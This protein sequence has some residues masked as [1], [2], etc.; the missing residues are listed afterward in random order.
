MFQYWNIG[1]FDDKKC[2]DFCNMWNKRISTLY[3]LT[4]AA[5]IA[6]IILNSEND[7]Q[8]TSISDLGIPKM[9]SMFQYW[10]IGNSATKKYN[11][12]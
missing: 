7:N 9:A 3:K 5:L 8:T 4:F 12:E 1:S 2:T 11:I 10:N 6:N